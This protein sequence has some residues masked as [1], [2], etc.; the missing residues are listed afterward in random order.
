MYSQCQ[1]R[2]CLC[3][4]WKTADEARRGEMEPENIP[5]PDEE[6]FHES[7]KHTLAQHISHLHSIPDEQICEMLGAIV[8]VENLYISMHKEKDDD[9]KRIYYYLFRVS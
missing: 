7:C 1:V 9:T 3:I 5:T 8:D 6:C 2:D 4:G